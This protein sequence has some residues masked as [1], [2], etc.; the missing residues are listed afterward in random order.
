MTAIRL[1][2]GDFITKAVEYL[3]TDLVDCQEIDISPLSCYIPTPV[4]YRKINHVIK[5]DNLPGLII[6][7]SNGHILKCACKH[8]LKREFIT[9]YGWTLCK[10]ILAENLRIGDYVQTKPESLIIEKIENCELD[11]YYD[12]SIDN[13]HEYYDANG[14]LHHNTIV[15]ASLSKLVQPYGRSIIIVPN[16]DLI[17]QTEADY[18]LINLDV[19]VFYGDRKELDKKHTICTW[20]SL[21]VFDKNSKEKLTEYEITQFLEDVVCVMV[22]EAHS[23]KGEVLHSLL[24]G[25]FK[26]VPIRWG[27]TGT[28]PLSEYEYVGLQTAIGSVVGEVTAKELQDKGFLADCAVKILQFEEDVIYDTYPAELRYLVTDKIRLQYIADIIKYVTTKGSSLILIDRID[29]GKQ[30][31]KLLP[32]SVFVSGE[33]DTDDR[34]DH[35][36]NINYTDNQILIA[37]YGV[38]AVGINIQRLFNII[39]IEPG[40]SFIKVIQ[41]IGRGLRT[42][43]DKNFVNIYDIGS[44]CKYAGRHLTKRKN[45]YKKQQYPYKVI[46]ID[47]RT[48][49][50]KPINEIIKE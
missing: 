23:A 11:N 20:Q 36:Q 32:N 27:L 38:A 14:I 30:L 47:Y 29:T 7:F 18:R 13:P 50:L 40:K 4:G 37:T 19:G 2:I 33:M 22:D 5:K 42:A 39:M 34:K 15:T 26:H 10:Y 28:I 24:T 1:K 48:D 6:T 45:Y 25:P 44:D 8:I 49:L 9:F 46:K 35:Y 12:I 3:Q 16:T 17:K 21:N 43:K 41:S 31:M